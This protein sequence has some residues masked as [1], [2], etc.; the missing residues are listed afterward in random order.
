TD[1]GLSR[2][3]LQGETAALV[4]CASSHSHSS[5]EKA[6]LLAGFGR[7]NLRLI[8]HDEKYGMRADLLAKA[9]E[10][11]WDSGRVPCAVVATT[12]TT[13]TT[14]LDPIAEIVKL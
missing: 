8:P 6:A 2:G 3:G 10:D 1:Y 11:D 4:V 5:V 9:V 13:T 7:Q 14:A 12:G